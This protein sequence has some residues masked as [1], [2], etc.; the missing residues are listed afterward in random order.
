MDLEKTAQLANQYGIATVLCLVVVGILCWVLKWVFDTSKAREAAMSQMVNVG[1]A[2]LA[3]SMTKLADSINANT[4]MI[5]EVT[6]E[7]R[8]GF[9]K[10]ADADRYQRD[11]HKNIIGLLNDNECKAK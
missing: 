10:L 5:Q 3:S 4:S 2:N 8:A 9:E 1:L 11:E 6:R 7:M